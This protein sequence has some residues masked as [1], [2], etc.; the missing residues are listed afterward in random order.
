MFCMG[1]CVFVC[2]WI[3]DT[4]SVNNKRSPQFIMNKLFNISGVLPEITEAERE[5]FTC[6]WQ[7]DKI[8]S[9]KCKTIKILLTFNLFE[10]ARNFCFVCAVPIRHYGILLLHCFP[11]LLNIF[12][13]FLIWVHIQLPLR[14]ILLRATGSI[15]IWSRKTIASISHISFLEGR[16]SWNLRKFYILSTYDGNLSHFGVEFWMWFTLHSHIMLHTTVYHRRNVL[17]K[18]YYSARPSSSLEQSLRVL[19]AL[20]FSVLIDIF[21]RDPILIELPQFQYV[22][23]PKINLKQN[24]FFFLVDGVVL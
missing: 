7:K 21:C 6:A 11:V 1:V 16:S 4:K 12:F 13:F 18:C 2:E 3:A 20:E 19:P 22:L 14:G 24:F 17:L 23:L 10:F 9:E 8:N 15:K 5:C